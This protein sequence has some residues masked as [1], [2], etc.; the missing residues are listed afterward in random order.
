M[1]REFRDGYGKRMRDGCAQRIS[2]LPLASPPQP[3][4]RRADI[5]A[6]RERYRADDEHEQECIEHRITQRRS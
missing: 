5:D 2:S 1:G 6:E 4:D 3:R